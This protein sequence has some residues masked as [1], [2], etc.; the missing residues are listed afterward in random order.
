MNSWTL[1]GLVRYRKNPACRPFSMSRGMALA[2][3]ATTGMCAVAGSS[4][5][6]KHNAAKVLSQ[7]L[8]TTPTP[9]TTTITPNGGSQHL[10]ERVLRQGMSGHDVRVLQGYLTLAGFATNIDGHFGA[11]T[12]EHTS[13]LQS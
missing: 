13:E 8:T 2:L 4:R 6:S 11:A 10:G 12:E 1:I 5:G 9:S 7:A 3:R